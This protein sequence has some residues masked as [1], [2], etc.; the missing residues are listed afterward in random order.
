MNSSINQTLV[1]G[2]EEEMWTYV[3]ILP[4][5]VSGLSTTIDKILNSEEKSLQVVCVQNILKKFDL[6]V[7]SNPNLYS[8]IKQLGSFLLNYHVIN[9]DIEL[10]KIFITLIV[11]QYNTS[12]FSL[13]ATS[14]PGTCDTVYTYE[15]DFDPFVFI[16]RC[17]DEPIPEYSS[18]HNF[19]G[20]VNMLNRHDPL[21]DLL[22]LCGDVEENPGPVQSTLN[23]ET[24][25]KHLEMELKTIKEQLKRMANHEWRQNDREKT[26][27]KKARRA[28]GVFSFM[29]NTGEAMNVLSNGLGPV[30]ESIKVAMESLTETG[31]KVKNVFG[32]AESIDVTGTLLSI[33]MFLKAILDKDLTMCTLIAM[34]ISR[35][36]GVTFSS[37]ISMVPGFNG[38]GVS[39]EDKDLKTSAR[40]G[41]GLFEDIL[42]KCSENVPIIAIGTTLVGI[43]TLF[44]KGSCPSVV[45]MTKHLLS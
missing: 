29:S 25:I 36:C 20:C 7:M 26:N 18:L 31:T 37:F 34:Q 9:E 41:Q 32:V 38:N 40:V 44:C 12:Q 24:K 22:K 27:R 21:V 14:V 35:M 6:N 16:Y 42:E 33:V 8:D 1:N 30:L 19:R 23:P 39:F 15:D 2:V 11:L 10:L 28:E 3:P 5:L 17:N 13:R 4:T 45:D 43:I